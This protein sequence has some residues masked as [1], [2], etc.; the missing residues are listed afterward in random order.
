MADS[1]DRIVVTTKDLTVRVQTDRGV[2]EQY[3]FPWEQK[4]PT[5]ER[6]VAVLEQIIMKEVRKAR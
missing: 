3:T 5:L 2:T 1:V 4:Y 6:A